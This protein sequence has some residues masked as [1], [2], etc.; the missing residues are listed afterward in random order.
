MAEFLSI[1]LHGQESILYQPSTCTETLT[2]REI[3][4][5]ANILLISKNR[6]HERQSE[7]R[8]I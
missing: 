4:T 3:S 6:Y 2:V 7:A 1:E 8:D 5:H